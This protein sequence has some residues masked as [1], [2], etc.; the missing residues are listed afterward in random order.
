M[1]ATEDSENKV[2]QYI[3]GKELGRGSFATVFLAD[4][5]KT[6]E[7]KAVKKIDRSRLS[8]K[9]LQNL[10]SEISILR[11][12]QHENIVKLYGIM[13]NTSHIFLFL[14][15]CG[16]GDLHKYIRMKGRLSE[17]VAQHFMR[18]L[19]QGLIFLWQKQLIHRDIKPQ[20]LLLSSQSDQATLKIADFGFARHLATA[21]LAETLCGSPL[22]M[23]PEI[24]MF[25]KYDGK[26][27]LWSAGTVLFEMLAGRPP[28][29]GA[30][31]SELVANI[32]TK[33]IKLPAGVRISQPCV[34]LI[35]MLLQ[36]KPTKRA[37]FEKFLGAE[38]IQPLNNQN[39]NQ[40]SLNQQNINSST[41]K[42]IS[43][44]DDGNNASNNQQT[45]SVVSMAQAA[46]AAVADSISDPWAPSRD[47]SKDS[48]QT[49]PRR[50]SMP[51]HLPSSSPIPSSSASLSS[52]Q[53][54]NNDVVA[55]ISESGEDTP[56]S[57]P[58][59]RRASL[60]SSIDP[61]SPDSGGTMIK[62]PYHSDNNSN[63]W[64]QTNGLQSA[65]GSFDPHSPYHSG[66]QTNNSL[67][68]PSSQLRNAPTAN[69]N[70]LGS[71][72]DSRQSSQASPFMQPLSASPPQGFSFNR[73]TQGGGGDNQPVVPSPHV[74]FSSP[75]QPMTTVAEGEDSDEW[76]V[77]DSDGDG[78]SGSWAAKTP[79]EV[80]NAKFDFHNHATLLSPRGKQKSF[81][82]VVN[83]EEGDETVEFVTR[84]SG[85][86]GNMEL[87]GRCAMAVARVG[88]GAAALVLSSQS[89]TPTSGPLAALV[90][91]AGDSDSGGPPSPI[92]PP[93]ALSPG[94]SFPNHK[95]S[96][97]SPMNQQP[98]SPSNKFT[99]GGPPLMPFPNLNPPSAAP[100]S[101]VSSNGGGGGSLAT[102]GSSSS[103]RSSS[104]S[105]EH[106][107]DAL[108][109]YLKA[110]GLV[111]RAVELGR[112]IIEKMHSLRSVH[113][114]PD[115][116][117][118]SARVLG[119]RANELLTWLS[120]QYTLLLDRA[121]K[122]REQ[123]V[124]VLVSP[125]SG[126]SSNGS[127]QTSQDNNPNNNN[128]NSNSINN[129]DN[130]GLAGRTGLRI[131][132]AALQL[133]RA[134]AIKEVLGNHD[135][136]LRMYKHGQLLIE[137]LLLEPNITPNDHLVLT[138]Y[139]H[140]FQARIGHL[141]QIIENP[142]KFDHEDILGD[143]QVPPII[144][145]EKQMDDDLETRQTTNDEHDEKDVNELNI[146]SH[147]RIISDDKALTALQ[148][149][150][151]MLMLQ[152]HSLRDH[153][154]PASPP[155]NPL[156]GGVGNA[157]DVPF[158]LDMGEDEGA[159]F[160]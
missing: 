97:I 65:H 153:A 83:G 156:S 125:I 77:V 30:N 151:P 55:T 5:E 16:G 159:A 31:Q 15:F 133:A 73:Y 81:N 132:G 93:S 152:P 60:P 92:S 10:E 119:G 14:E 150:P 32:R 76:L 68:I 101:S 89:Y 91:D 37:S 136:S 24:L 19:A 44:G 98:D 95:H 139:D 26:A 116:D 106:L 117:I 154:G 53:S 157:M 121:E 7:K 105:E 54:P 56:W 11:D 118:T 85:M 131:Y 109:L 29:G 63:L 123:R 27:D 79:R 6:G 20:N 80:N 135:L 115:L 88:D 78:G 72:Y 145:D 111:K 17:P 50:N 141:K 59:S 34:V 107:S 146:P 47:S 75:S 94:S 8:P 28:Y 110:M 69:R 144:N 155:R 57:D 126:S 120:S 124:A 112:S 2:G 99:S 100:S 86:V 23:A 38:F 64:S 103:L 113:T 148:I 90:E 62:S 42:E 25:Q 134:A 82:E 3:L 114:R 4:H 140:G 108:L 52:N 122:C 71:P 149:A 22:Y 13:K 46:A 104:T 84:L 130:R 18:H 51:T 96:T 36:R 67:K 127:V 39:Q 61:S 48:P 21:S 33:E 143:V 40:I 43:E 129:N 41:M 35:Q 160:A 12:F 137:A 58:A 45:N 138:N 102:S 49:R 128:N 158:G 9:L 74:E 1:S 70:T 142:E 66:Y 147:P 87:L